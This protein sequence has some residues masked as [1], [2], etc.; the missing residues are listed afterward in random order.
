MFLRPF[1]ISKE[2][3]KPN[4]TMILKTLFKFDGIEKE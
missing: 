3:Y 1:L 4:E 2:R